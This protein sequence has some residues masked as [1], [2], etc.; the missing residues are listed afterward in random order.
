MRPPLL[1]V[2]EPEPELVL[3]ELEP[4]LPELEP[5]DELESINPLY[6]TLV[7]PFIEVDPSSKL[8]PVSYPDSPNVPRPTARWAAIKWCTFIVLH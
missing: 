4:E 8:N 6:W 7:A 2:P 1:L 5:D 3:P